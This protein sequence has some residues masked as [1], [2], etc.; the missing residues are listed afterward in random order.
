MFSSVPVLTEMGKT[1]LLRAAG[2]E[3]F[4]LTKFQAGNGILSSGETPETMTALKSVKV[5]NIGITQAEDTEDD[6]YIQVTGTFDNQ[7]DVLTDFRWT[8]LGLIAED[9]EG[10][11]YLYAYAYDDEYAELIHAGGSSVVVEQTVSFIVS[12]GDTENITASILPN[13]TYASKSSFDTHVAATHAHGCTASDVGAAAAEHSHSASDIDSGVV[14][15]E[16]GGTGVSSLAELAIALSGLMSLNFVVGTFTG[17]GRTRKD[18]SLGFQP[19]AVILIR[20]SGGITSTDSG[21][22]MGFA[23]GKNQYHSGC[24]TSYLTAST[25]SMLDRA[26]A[27]LG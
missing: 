4:T 6:G 3:E 19:S 18:I 15:V 17:D 20:I 9:G 24:G 13:A 1:L 27:A 12:I 22:I 14:S 26:T 5:A 2:G 7:T 23:P 25:D 10:N 16:R 8:E 11:E 21:S